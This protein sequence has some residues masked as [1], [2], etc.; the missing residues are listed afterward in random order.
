LD[1]DTYQT[2]SKSSRLIFDWE[3]LTLQ[4]IYEHSS[5]MCL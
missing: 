4:K 1:P 2:L 3:G 5:I